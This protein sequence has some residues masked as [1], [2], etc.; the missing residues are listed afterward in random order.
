MSDILQENASL[1]EQLEAAKKD[2]AAQTDTVLIL[3]EQNKN[4]LE[5]YRQLKAQLEA[6]EQALGEALNL[7]EKVLFEYDTE[8]SEIRARINRFRCTVPTTAK[9]EAMQAND[10]YKPLPALNTANVN[11]KYSYGGK[12]KPTLQ[13]SEK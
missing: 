12:G 13:E 7:F 8:C 4:Y 6:S 1:K 11:V 10:D 9:A 2:K 3:S 5:Q